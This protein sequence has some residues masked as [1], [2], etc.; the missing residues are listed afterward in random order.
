M[1]EK[2]CVGIE[3]IKEIP[4]FGEGDSLEGRLRNVTLRGF[5]DVK[6]YQDARFEI[7][8]MFPDQI[9]ENLHT[10]QLRVYRTHLERV[11]K[12]RELFLKEGIDILCLDKAYDYVA[13]DS[14]GEQTEWTM[15]PPVAEIFS[16]P[17]NSEGQMDY[18]QLIGDEVRQKLKESGLNLNPEVLDLPLP[19]GNITLINDGSHRIHYGVENGGIK[20]LKIR[21]VTPG[22][23]YYAAPQKYEGVKVFPTREE[24]VNLPE[25]KVHVTEAPGHKDLY[26]LFPTGGIL[27]G[28]VRSDKKLEE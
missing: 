2:E 21:G 17:Q 24:A 14:E 1:S 27:S 28:T 19:T 9:K 3:I 8:F 22:F 20:I 15:L 25:T 12:L 11:G 5:P 4:F 7:E 18:N 6:I 23:P 26:R 10:P 16:T 13:T